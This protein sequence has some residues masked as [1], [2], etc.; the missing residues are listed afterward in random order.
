MGLQWIWGDKKDSPTK[1][2]FTAKNKEKIFMKSKI[3]VHLLLDIESPISEDVQ[4]TIKTSKV[5]FLL[6]P[7]TTLHG[8]E[9]TMIEY[10]G[11]G[12]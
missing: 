1:L 3:K 8:V 10:L 9:L 11:R 6:P 7:D 2:E 4:K 12:G 5:D